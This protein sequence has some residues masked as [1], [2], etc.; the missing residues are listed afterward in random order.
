MLEHMCRLR[1]FNL[2]N[3][4]G[5]LMLL[6]LP[7]LLPT[8]RTAQKAST[9]DIEV[10]LAARWCKS[11]RKPKRFRGDRFA[12]TLANR[13]KYFYSFSIAPAK[14]PLFLWRAVGRGRRSPWPVSRRRICHW[15]RFIICILWRRQ[16]LLRRFTRKHLIAHCR[17]I[18]K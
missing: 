10:V 15:R 9:V 13:R 17:V 7:A 2:G 12:I 3:T 18:D 11:F 8:T 4:L 6:C 16:V 14:K 5:R 1:L